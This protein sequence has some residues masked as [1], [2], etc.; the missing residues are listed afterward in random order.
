M[1]WKRDGKNLANKKGSRQAGKTFLRAY[2]TPQ[3]QHTPMPSRHLACYIGRAPTPPDTANMPP[4]RPVTIPYAE[5]RTANVDSTRTIVLTLFPPNERGN[6]SLLGLAERVGS[7][8]DANTLRTRLD[9]FVELFNWLRVSDRRI[10]EPLP[11]EPQSRKRSAPQWKR[12][13]VWLS[14][15]EASP[16]VLE[17]YRAA[18]AA[19]LDETDAVAL[20]AES[21]LPNDRGLVPETIDRLFRI[22]LPAPREETD[23]ARLFLRLFPT[24]KEVDRFFGLPSELFDRIALLASPGDGSPAWNKPIAALLDAFCLLGARVQGLGLSEK[25]RTRSQCARVQES[26]F[27]RLPRAGDALVEAVRKNEDV[28]AAAMLWKS[29][30]GEC[31]AEL[32]NIVDH[33]NTRGV[34]LDIVYALDVIEKSLTRMEIIS[35]LLVA[36]PGQPKL[37]TAQRLMKEVIRGRV[38]DRSLVNLGQNSFRLLARKI[39]EWA[40][41]TGEHYITSNR[42]EYAQM[43]KAALGGGLLTVGTAAIKLMV[44]HQ[45]LPPFVEGFLAGLNYAVSFVLMQNFH[46]ALAT[47]QPSMTGAT[48]ARIIHHCR[49]ASKSD[50]LA[51]YVARITRSQLAAALG[52]IVAVSAGAIVFSMLWKWATGAPFLSVET[53]EYAVTS[54]NPLHSGTIFYAM[55]TGVI[56]W[57]SS[58]AGGWIE[59]WA[60]YHQLPRAI[61]E[62]RLGTAVSPETLTRISESLSRNIAGWG[63]SIVLG[64]MLGMTPVVGHFFGVPLDVRHVTLSTGTLALGVTSRG[65]EVLGH[66]V[67]LWAALGI[68]VTFVLNLGVSFY[69][70]LRLALRA[71]DVSPQDHLAILRT[72]WRHF[73][74]SPAEFFLPLKQEATSRIVASH[75]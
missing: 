40:G 14:V 1:P 8:T 52:N 27:Y 43:W 66:G 65:P 10:P 15:L 28:P 18:M 35:G 5:E 64:F 45:G 71:Q 63:G 62:H 74:A 48:L 29:T 25:L 12:E 9:A 54:L 13:R 61:E 51:D 44:T 6:M 59:N 32:T 36:Q 26:P 11:R 75:Q 17:R 68:A 72:L 2:Q 50:E 33:L 19:I 57:L 70:A 4:T 60:V 38:G 42:D 39:I 58:L 16:Q 55:L 22:V 41:K 37:L 67:L 23:L 49:D 7:F 53:A 34:N 20:F 73:R 31:R 30:V 46:L 69:L 21:G 47:K 56:L 3:P 24:Q